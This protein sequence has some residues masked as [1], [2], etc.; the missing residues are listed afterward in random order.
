MSERYNLVSRTGK[1]QA[2]ARVLCENAASMN[3]FKGK[4]FRVNMIRYSGQEPNVTC[5]IQF[6]ISE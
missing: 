3:L 2:E 5:T 1:T 4:N 6:V